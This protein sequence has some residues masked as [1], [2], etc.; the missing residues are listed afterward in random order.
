MNFR[1]RPYLDLAHRVQ[2]CTHCGR[3]VDHGCDPAHENGIVA[4]KGLSIKSHDLHA[5]LCGACH[6]WYDTGKGMD[7]TGVFTE[8]KEDKAEMWNRAHKATLRLYLSN[9]WLEVAA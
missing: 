6:R 3:W 2:E 5:A 7:P 8:S 9:K 1:S 4:G